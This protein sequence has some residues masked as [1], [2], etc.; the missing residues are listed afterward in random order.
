MTANKFVEILS[1]MVVVAS[2]IVAA[3]AIGILGLFWFAL[4]PLLRSMLG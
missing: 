2:G 3:A 4:R 1:M